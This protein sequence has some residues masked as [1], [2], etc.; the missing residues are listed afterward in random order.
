MLVFSICLAL[1]GCGSGTGAAPAAKPAKTPITFTVGETQSGDWGFPSPYGF[2]PRG[3]GSERMLMIFDTLTWRDDT[4]I[5]PALATKWTYN[6]TENSY[7]LELSQK[8]KWHDGTQFTSKDVVFTFEYTRKHPYPTDSTQDLIGK[9]EAQGDYGVKIYL[10]KVYAPFVTDVLSGY[11]MLPEHV[12]AKVTDPEKLR[13]PEALV[14][15]GPFKLLQH[16]SAQG[17]YLYGANKDYYQGAPKVDQVKYMFVNPTLVP[18]SLK[19]GDIDCCEVIG[20][21]VKQVKAS[22]TTVIA[23]SYDW[24]IKVMI[25]QKKAPYSS[26]EFRQALAYAIDRDEVVKIAR[27]GQGLPGNI[28]ILPPD[29]EWYD[30]GAAQ[31]A[32]NPQKAKEILGTLGYKLNGTY[33]AKGGKTLEVNL[34]LKSGTGKFD[35]RKEAEVVKQDLEKVGIKV[36]LQG[37]EPKTVDGMITKWDFELAIT[38]HG[39]LEGD[40]DLL[41]RFILDKSFTS[42]R[43]LSD[44][45]LTQVLGQ[46]SAAMD[47]VARKSLVF[48]AQEIIAQDVPSIPL[49]YQQSF[50]AT[51]GRV[52]LFYNKPG[53]VG[54]TR[55]TNKEA[56]LR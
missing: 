41:A 12:W 4:G 9:V 50:W 32:Y 48:K 34:L 13:S 25:N 16:D 19:N 6:P 47:P 8:A 52:P 56:F 53:F 23:G 10:K 42:A 7:S 55:P 46:Q 22:G 5:V 2:Y 24:L 17:T 35:N 27:M 44:T 1:F 31:Y 33:L 36:N 20:A 11:P 15:T 29:S 30:A 26:K 21:Q 14:G 18:A 40:P 54:N 37:L 45:S 49:T 43:F 39:G 38:G 3:P 28:G 51:D